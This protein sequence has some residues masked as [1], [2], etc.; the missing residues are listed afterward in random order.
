M[1]LQQL[2]FTPGIQ[3]DGS[4]YSSS[5][6]WSEADKVRFRDGAAEKIGGWQKAVPEQF[7]GT[8]R[9][10]FAFTDLTGS[11]YLGIGTHLKYYVERGGTLYDITPI[12]ATISA[13]NPFTTSTASPIVSVTIANHGATLG[14]FVI[15]S[16]A[17]SVGGLTLNGEYQVQSPI[18]SSTFYITASSSASSGAN[19]GGSVTASFQI[20]TSTNDTLYA[21]GWGA[22]TWGGILSAKSVAFTGSIS[23]TIL[24][25]TA[26]GSG[27]I[28]A[29]QLLTGVGVSAG[30]PGSNATYISNQISGTTGGIGTYTV[31]VSQT[32]ASTSMSAFT[33]TGWGDASDTQ[34]ASTRLRLW[35]NDNYGQDLIIN[36]RD[37]AIYYWYSTGGL[38]TRAVKLSGFAGASDVP[39]VARQIM[40]SA[41]DRKVLAFGCT[42]VD[43]GNPSTIPQQDRLLIRWS[44]TQNPAQWTPLETNAAGGLRI[45][46]G[47]EFITA[48]K[49][50]QEILV[51]TDSAVHALKYIGAPYEYTITRLGMASIAAPNAIASSNDVVFWMGSNGFFQYDGRVYGLPCSVKDYVFNDLNLKQ[52]DKIAAGSNMSFNEVW[53]FYPSLNSNENDRYVVYNYNEKIWTIGNIARTAWLD[54]SI[55]DF[56]R[57]AGTDGY[58]YFHELGQDDGS[59]NPYSPIV[60]YIESAPIEIGVGENFGFAWRM[61]PD[62]TFRNSINPNAKVDFVLKAQDFSGS[63]FSQTKDNNAEYISNVIT[64]GGI[65]IVTFPVEQFTSQTYFRLRGRMM[66]LRVQSDGVGVAWR[67]G[68]P[69]VDIRDD[70][71]R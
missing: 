57:S 62:L 12:R 52:A 61:I 50:K 51:W 24:T 70:G 53:W 19:G 5:G 10:L 46:T 20:S 54:R 45:P 67:L 1:P 47:S 42:E 11:Y 37:S 41:L 33:G 2:K 25:V 18:T 35:S 15:F 13:S 58:I 8:C 39:A 30:P 34:V 69:R 59:T 68:V 21:N 7:L 43:D 14:D 40:V 26:V 32:V 22:G 29:G 27:A 64:P 49:A 31:S 71:R 16:G 66:T 4:R 63:A 65:T 3:H 38:G 9:Q 6:S 36:P 55:E 60:A 56:P 23:G 17:S 44:D 48:V 28:T